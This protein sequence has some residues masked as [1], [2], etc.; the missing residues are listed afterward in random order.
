MRLD[1]IIKEVKLHLGL[2]KFDIKVDV[3]GHGATLLNSAFDR[4]GFLSEIYHLIT[5]LKYF[6]EASLLALEDVHTA[7]NSLLVH[8]DVINHF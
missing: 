4:F 3:F 8:E 1:N 5:K 2:E 7:V 6:E